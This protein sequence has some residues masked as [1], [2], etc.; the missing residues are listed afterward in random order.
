MLSKKLAL[1]NIP[2]KISGKK[3]LIR[4]DFNVPLKDGKV[5]DSTRIKESLA[6][7]KFAKDNGAKAITIM[8][9][10]GRPDGFKKMKF[11]LKPI[12]ETFS[13]LLKQEVHFLDDCVGQNVQDTVA[14]ADGGKIILLEN[15]R[16]YAAEEGSSVDDNKVKTKEK[17][18]VIKEF[19]S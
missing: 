15:L 2:Q 3:V 12:V 19:R 17:P 8:S 5:S 7:I 4:V 6:S 16:F 11:S 10:L 13:N 1:A 14:K 9:H 18:E